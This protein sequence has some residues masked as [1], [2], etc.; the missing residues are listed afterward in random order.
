[1]PAV[2]V[3]ELGAGHLDA[4]AKVVARGMR[5]NPLHLRTFGGDDERRERV[6]ARFFRPVLGQYLPKGT[7]LGAFQAGHLVGVCG[8]LPP[9]RI[10]TICGTTA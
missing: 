7:I 4:A 1:M 5:D 10:L 6:L 9:G 8:M 3:R 2:E